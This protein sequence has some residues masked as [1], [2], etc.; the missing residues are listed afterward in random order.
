MRFF[1]SSAHHTP[2]T[3]TA[4]DKQCVTIH[5]MKWNELKWM[6]MCRNKEVYNTLLK[7]CEKCNDQHKRINNQH[8][9]WNYC[10]LYHSRTHANVRTWHVLLLMMAISMTI[11]NRMKKRERKSTSIE[12]VCL[13]LF[14]L[15]LEYVLRFLRFDE[16]KK[17][18]WRTRRPAK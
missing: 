6:S 5:K 7:C 9:K 12:F 13:Y 3:T 14:L 1:L 17:M 2:L 10:V 8:A 15:H 4:T 16:W 18:K 11:F